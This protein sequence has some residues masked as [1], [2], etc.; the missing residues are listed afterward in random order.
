M[1]A[2]SLIVGAFL[3][4]LDKRARVKCLLTREQVSILAPFRL[5]LVELLNEF[6]LVLAGITRPLNLLIPLR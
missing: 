6:L 2:S 5:I 1:V 3:T 4:A